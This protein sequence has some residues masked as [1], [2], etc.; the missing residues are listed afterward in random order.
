MNSNVE[1]L[2]TSME[3][4]KRITKKANL[5][6]RKYIEDQ[7]KAMNDRMSLFNNVL[8]NRNPHEV[9]PSRNPHQA[10]QASIPQSIPQPPAVT[11]HDETLIPSPEVEEASE[12]SIP[13]ASFSSI[14]SQSSR[15]ADE[16]EQTY[17]N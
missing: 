10:V 14:V 8:N 6:N 16:R 3:E 15:Q 4:H 9:N 11:L 17:N 12:E 5:D 13:S 2:Y 7:I 1:T